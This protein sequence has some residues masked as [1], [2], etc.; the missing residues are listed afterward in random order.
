MQHDPQRVQVTRSVRSILRRLLI[1]DGRNIAVRPVMS[2]R[3]GFVHR[4]PVRYGGTEGVRRM[5]EHV[6]RRWEEQKSFILPRLRAT[7]GK[8]VL[9]NG[10]FVV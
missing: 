5:G 3:A 4:C 6:F 1:V 7:L 10:G 8:L 9:D 2:N